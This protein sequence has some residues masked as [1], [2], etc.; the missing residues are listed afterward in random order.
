VSPSKKPAAPIL[1][2]WG[3]D[4]F[5]LR[6]AAF[7]R[8]GDLRPVEVDAAEWRGTELGDLMTPSLFG[9]ARALLVHDAKALSR[10]ALAELAAYAAAPDPSSPLVLCAIVGERAKVPAALDKV[11]RP[12]GEMREVKAPARKDLEGWVV[13]RA[14]AT[15]IDLAIPAARALVAALGESPAE[16]A[17]ALQQL[18]SAFP[19]ERITADHVARQ[20]R[21]LGEQKTWD[22]CDKAF[23]KDLPGAIR[24]LRSIEEGG[25]DPLLV[26]GG[27]AA[28]LRDLIRV[29]ALPERL[30]PAEVP[31]RA[32]LRFDWQARRYQQQAR[33]FSM[34]RLV[35]LH[36]QLTEADRALKSGA[37]GE[38]VMPGLIAAIAS[39]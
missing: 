8:L 12:V 32:G 23:G 10:E 39:E 30:P 36:E 38:V 5:L 20:F 26:L 34:Q 11:V 16:L 35:D 6:E 25:D 9:E 14:R 4:D 22:L 18:A 15:G 37:S 3:E 28:R 31:K 13:S 2:L 21:G 1:L 7:E 17:S 24:S 33:A 19:G 27:I 29:R